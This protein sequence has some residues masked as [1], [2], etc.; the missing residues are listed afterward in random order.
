MKQAEM[1]VLGDV[2]KPDNPVPQH[3]IE[4]CKNKQEAIALCVKWSGIQDS[5]ICHAL[6]LDKGNFSRYMTGSANFPHNLENALQDLCG[7]EAVLQWACC[8]RNQRPIE[9][10]NSQKIAE[11][12][13]Q[14]AEMREA[15]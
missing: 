3:L 12:E 8:S 4:L 14:L 1:P 5:T 13:K 10:D 9:I 2:K 6:G 7:N 15:S 11:L